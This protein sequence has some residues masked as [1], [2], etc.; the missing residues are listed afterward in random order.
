MKKK[1]ISLTNYIVY[2]MLSTILFSGCTTKGIVVPAKGLSFDSDVDYVKYLETRLDNLK[3]F[4]A[5][6]DLKISNS[7]K[8]DSATSAILIKTP[9]DIRIES[10][11]VFGQSVF[12]FTS[13][14]DSFS[15]FVPKENKYFSGANSIENLKKVLPLDVTIDEFMSYLTGNFLK[16]DSD[17]VVV[18]FLEDKK[19]YKIYYHNADESK[20]VIWLDRASLTVTRCAVYN[21]YGDIKST[22]TYS[23]FEK[24]EGMMF[25]KVITIKFPEIDAKIDVKYDD[26]TVN[27]EIKDELFTLEIPRKAKVVILDSKGK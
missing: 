4:K 25:P 11:S 21:D 14:K 23:D 19:V 26:I 15:I 22:A 16:S 7:K 8:S 17:N 5:G 3:T 20:K 10:Y 24:I 18:K 1:N 9:N 6:G 13:K 27:S 2:I 12:F